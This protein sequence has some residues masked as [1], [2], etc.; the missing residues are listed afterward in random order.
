M[1]ALL[2][3]LIGAAAAGFCVEY[4]DNRIK[5]PDEIESHLGTSYLGLV[6]TVRS[7]R[8]R[9][10]HAPLLI[11]RSHTRFGEALRDVRTAVVFA[12]GGD[13]SRCLAVTSTLPGEGKTLISTNLA[14]V[15]AQ[16]N[17]RVLI[18]DADMRKPRVHEMLKVAREPGLSEV[19]TD[20]VP[21]DEAIRPTFMPRLFILSAGGD[22]G[23]PSELIGSDQFRACLTRAREQYD[24]VIVDT[25]PVTGVTDATLVAHAAGA[26]ML[27]V[28]N[29]MT[30]RGA[31]M[32]AVKRLRT[33]KARML[34]AVLNRVDIEHQAYYYSPYYHRKYVDHYHRQLN[35]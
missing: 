26:V 9:E 14:V 28:G 5:L 24:W 12:V 20:K 8:R 13:G 35:G 18:V 32:H 3:G 21:F 1:L 30:S 15:L 23:N 11:H 27:V 31:A 19:L 33:A 16:A 10:R 4:L 25:P 17:H 2:A 29:E 22:A 6:P 34:G 7:R